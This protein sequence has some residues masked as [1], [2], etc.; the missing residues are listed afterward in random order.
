MKYDPR[1]NDPRTFGEF[2]T[3]L[4]FKFGIGRK[5]LVVIPIIFV[6]ILAIVTAYKGAYVIDEGAKGVELRLGKY[7]RTVGP[8]LNFKIPYIDE[9]VQV[10][11]ARIFQAEFGFRTTARNKKGTAAVQQQESYTTD[12]EALMLTGDLNVAI[13]PWIVQF[14]VVDPVKFLFAAQNPIEIMRDMSEATVRA[15]VGDR[16]VDNVI[17]DRSI[18]S[19]DAKPALQKQLDIVDIGIRVV[20]VEMQKIDVPDPVKAS[21]HAVNEA[22]QTKQQ[23]IQDAWGEYN[24]VVPKAA[25]QAK[26]IV[27]E[28]EGYA[29]EKVNNALGETARFTALY[30]EYQKKPAI[31]M[32]RLYY[33]SMSK[34]I[35]KSEGIKVIDDDI[36]GLLPLLNLK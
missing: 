24:K 7:H 17:K 14:Q 16:S 22:E 30:A 20:A 25:G 28:A 18:I 29:M 27:Q 36:K 11:T 13:V 4:R 23:V 35:V 9:K 26:Q 21:F 32:Q 2:L 34:L 5:T 12:S 33:E 3:F 10:R 31:T 8:G 6:A 19:A 1:R 15:I